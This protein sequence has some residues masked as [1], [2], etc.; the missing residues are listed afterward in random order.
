LSSGVGGSTRF[1]GCLGFEPK[2]AWLR[3]LMEASLIGG[4]VGSTAPFNSTLTTG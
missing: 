3:W 2:V 1:N 4:K